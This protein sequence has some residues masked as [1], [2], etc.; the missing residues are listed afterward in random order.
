MLNVESA[1]KDT[2]TIYKDKK[3]EWRWRRVAVNGN[4]VGA[5][6]EGYVK[7]SD[8]IDNAKRQF[9]ECSITEEE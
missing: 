1:K 9:V 3:G 6:S 2:L 5:S 7:K 8:C 4:N